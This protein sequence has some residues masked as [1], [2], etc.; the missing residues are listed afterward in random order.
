M[1]DRAA[2]LASQ[3]W[4]GVVRTLADL[5]C[6][7]GAIGAAIM[8]LERGE[9]VPEVLAAMRAADEPNDPAALRRAGKR[10]AVR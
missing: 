10:A 9:R 7:A 8:A 4:P 2:E 5:G 1:A 6:S 3:G